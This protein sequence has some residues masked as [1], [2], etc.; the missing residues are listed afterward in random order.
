MPGE[1]GGAASPVQYG[2]HI[3]TVG[4]A[5]ARGERVV[6][7]GFGKFVHDEGTWGASGRIPRTGKA[8]AIAAWRAPAFKAIREAVCGKGCWSREGAS[9]PRTGCG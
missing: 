3:S 9:R 4:E 6:I 2:F 1:G 7:P 8:I 5:L